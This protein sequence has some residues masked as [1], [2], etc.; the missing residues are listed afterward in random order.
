MYTANKF[1]QKWL[2]LPENKNEAGIGLY[3]Q[4]EVQSE[5]SQ[6]EFL[7]SLLLDHILGMLRPQ[8]FCLDQNISNLWH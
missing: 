4:L 1:I 2:D 8:R 7:K 5:V 3:P 6:N